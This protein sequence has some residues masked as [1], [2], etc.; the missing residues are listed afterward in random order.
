MAI[1][2][3]DIFPTADEICITA[4]GGSIC[5]P[6]KQPRADIELF[7]IDVEIVIL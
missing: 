3:D 5:P 6:D 2:A 1:T 4:D 7:P